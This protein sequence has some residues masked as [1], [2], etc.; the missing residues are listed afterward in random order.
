MQENKKNKLGAEESKGSNKSHLF[1]DDGTFKNKQ[2]KSMGKPRIYKTEQ[3]YLI[4][5]VL[6]V[7]RLSMQE[8]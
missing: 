3:S 7:K 1:T 5:V 6:V 2:T 4:Q 8:T